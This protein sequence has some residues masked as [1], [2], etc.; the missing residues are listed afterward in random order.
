MSLITI[1]GSKITAVI[2]T[3][4]AEV[5]SLK[6]E[7]GVERLW[8][9]DPAFWTGCAPILFPVAGGFRDDCYEL[10]GKRYPM[11]K[12]GF[13][14]KKEWQVE[15]TAENKAVFLLQERTP[16]S[17]S[18]TTCG[19]FSRRRKIIFPSPSRFPAG[20]KSPSISASA[21][22]KPTPLPKA[23]RITRSSLTKRKSWRIMCWTA[24]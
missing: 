9:R 15:E 14:K 8:Q 20:M 2:S 18:I 7:N 10:D 19:P 4:G 12:H 5:Q 6:D 11:P 23:S 13:A 3:L 24:T 17:P 21:P 22:T 1:K 16:A